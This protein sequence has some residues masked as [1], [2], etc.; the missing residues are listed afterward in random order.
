MASITR[1][2]TT[3]GVRYDVRY[4][5]PDG[6][7]RTATK[8]TKKEAE[9]FAAIVESGWA[10][11][12]WRMERP[13]DAA[14]WLTDWGVTEHPPEGGLTLKALGP[15]PPGA[16]FQPTTGALAWLVASDLFGDFALRI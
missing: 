12:P 7:V 3:R 14:R 16:K 8:R 4:R 15:Q 9:Q 11:A 1:R 5:L 10:T 2:E 6:K 13:L